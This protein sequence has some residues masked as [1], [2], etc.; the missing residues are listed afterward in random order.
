MIS[1]EEISV[2]SHVEDV[3]QALELDDDLLDIAMLEV[4]DEQFGSLLISDDIF[5]DLCPSPTM[6]TL[7]VVNFMS[8]VT[9]DDDD[10]QFSF[11]LVNDDN[12]ALLEERYKNTLSKLAEFMKR[13]QETRRSLSIGK[14]P[15]YPRKNSITGVLSSIEKSS[16]KVQMYLQLAGKTMHSR[17]A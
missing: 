10:D 3:F 1:D 13:T 14:N 15:N 12:A 11:F 7:E 16:Q 9:E 2:C 4:E 5:Q 8:L 17:S 6:D